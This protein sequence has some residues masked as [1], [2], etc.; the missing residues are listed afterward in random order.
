VSTQPVEF[1]PD[2]LDLLATSAIS[3]V[4][5]RVLEKAEFGLRRENETV[6]KRFHSWHPAKLPLSRRMVAQPRD[7]V[8][9]GGYWGA[10]L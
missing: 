9:S 1:S 2:G 7:S 5:L 10:D 3:L 8:D 4:V 6:H